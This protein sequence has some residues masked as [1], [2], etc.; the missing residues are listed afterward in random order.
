MSEIVSYRCVECGK[1]EVRPAVIAYDAEVK[2]DGRLCR[3]SINDLHVNRCDAC[4]EVFF[5]ATTDAQISQ[6]LRQ[7]LQL[8]S[9]REIREGIQALGL[10][11]REFAEQTGIAAETISRWLSGAYI[12]SR[13]M[14]TLMRMFFEREG[15]K[16]ANIGPDAVAATHPVSEL[17]EG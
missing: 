11:Q 5:D 10:T 14:N 9:P 13:A 8:L 6:G 15:A 3:F 12:Q 4:G 7:H 17:A 16:P 2:H 1:T